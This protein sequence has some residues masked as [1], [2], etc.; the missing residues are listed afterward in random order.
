MRELKKTGVN[1][2][3]LFSLCLA[4]KTFILIW[5][6]NPLILSKKS[7]NKFLILDLLVSNWGKWS[8]ESIISI[9]A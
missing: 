9:L 2:M 4:R 1:T 7:L 6:L 8:F 3:S 5:Y